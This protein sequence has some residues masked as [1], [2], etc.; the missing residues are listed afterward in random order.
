MVDL[1][2]AWRS[3]I[4]RQLQG[5]ISLGLVCK[6]ASTTALICSA[7]NIGLRPRPA[8]ICH[9]HPNPCAAKRLRMRASA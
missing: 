3:A 4:S 2:I 6:V 8:A 1:L 9:K 7:P 5:V